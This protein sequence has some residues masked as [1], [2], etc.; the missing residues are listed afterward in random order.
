MIDLQP[1]AQVSLSGATWISPSEKTPTEPGHRPAYWLR[2]HFTWGPEDGPATVHATAHGIYELFVN[3]TRV[4]HEELTPGCTSY[5]KRLQVQSWDITPLLAAAE[6]NEVSALLSD[7]WFRGRH[8]FERRANGFGAE[9]AFLGAIR[10][11]RRTLLTTGPQWASRESH[12]TRADL[13]DGQATDF[14]L[15]CSLGEGTT[16]DGW[17]PVVPRRNGLYADRQRLVIQTEPGVRRIE[18]LQ[19]V[20]VT[21]PMP[22]R[23]VVD[24]GQNINGWV[25]WT[26]LGPSGTRTRLVHGEVLDDTGSVTTEHLRAF[27][28]ASGAKLPAG[29]VDEVISAGRAG[30]VFE[31]RHTTHGFRYVQLDRDGD[32]PTPGDITAVVVHSDLERTGHFEC[33]DPRLNALHDAVL[34][35]FRGNACDVPTD[36]PQRERSGFTGDWQVFVDTAALMYDVSGFSAKWLRDLASDQWPDG[37]VPTVVPNPAGDGPSGNAFEDLA[38]GSAGWGDAAVFVPWSLWRAYGEDTLLAEAFP[39]MCAW[40]DYAAGIASSARHPERAARRPVPL[41]HEQYLWDTGF[42]FGEWLE[43]DTPPNPDPTRDHGILATAYLHRSASLLAAAARVLGNAE[44]TS[45]YGALSA[46]A[47]AAWQKEYLDHHGRLREESQGHYVRALAFG[48]VPEHLRPGTAARLVELIQANGGR[49]GTGFL[50][51]GMLLPVLADHGYL[52]VAYDLLLST[53]E[54]SWLGMLDAGATTMWEWWDGG[55]GTTAKGSLNHYSK[56]AVA[57][58]LYTHVA[59]IRL[60]DNPDAEHAAYRSVTIAPQ[61][62]GGI[63]SASAAVETFRGRVSAAWTM[64]AGKFDLTIELPAGSRAT[65]KL[66]DGSRHTVVGGQHQFDCTCR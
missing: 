43:P 56:G 33:S 41:P 47:L 15:H 64:K 13:M 37:R 27:E 11:D 29:Q 65:V 5:R 57:S 23:T 3:G 2:G 51:T 44:A 42:H 31:P 61:P 21:Y 50:A 9:T 18:E 16:P 55:S 26:T 22:G 19:P 59:G 28:F 45:R 24:F 40:V 39:P 10:T 38:A 32:A 48:L 34:W 60:P 30:D 62:G 36:C 54:P 17:L 53:E 52:D 8:G 12:I 46:N 14:R 49:L 35:S 7:G 1:S 63:T 4:G 25:R 20:A 66:P 58:F 6:E